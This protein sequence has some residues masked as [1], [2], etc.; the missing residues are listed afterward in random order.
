MFLSLVF[1]GISVLNFGV[2]LWLLFQGN[3]AVINFSLFMAFISL[4]VLVIFWVNYSKNKSPF[5]RLASIL[6]CLAMVVIAAID[7]FFWFGA[8]YL[9]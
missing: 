8:N 6:F 2:G 9:E 7:L 5:K 3:F 4:V 1:V